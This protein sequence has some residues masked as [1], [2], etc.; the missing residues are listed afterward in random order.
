MFESRPHNP[1]PAA[2]NRLF[3]TAQAVARTGKAVAHAGEILR[4]RLGGLVMY[5]IAFGS[6][7]GV[8]DALGR[9]QDHLFSVRGLFATMVMLAIPAA[10]FYLGKRNMAK[11][12]ALKHSA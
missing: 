10:F 6:S 7:I 11:A 3:D 12:R 2:S 1:G 4:L 9:H 5:W 8:L